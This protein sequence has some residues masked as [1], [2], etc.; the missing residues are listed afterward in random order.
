MRSSYVVFLSLCLLASAVALPVTEESFLTTPV[1]AWSSAAG[2]ATQVPNTQTASEL[3]Q[4]LLA[5]LG[6]GESADEGLLSPLG[7]APEILVLFVEPALSTQDFL[8][9]SG[10]HAGSPTSS[11]PFANVRGFLEHQNA[12]VLENVALERH[13]LSQVL[14]RVAAKQLRT[15]ITSSLTLAVDSAVLADVSLALSLPASLSP[16]MRSV[17]DV[18]LLP[19]LLA[20]HPA[21]GSNGVTDLVVVY[22]STT[23]GLHKLSE[24]FSRDDL[25]VARTVDAVKALTADYVALL[26]SEVSPVVDFFDFHRSFIPDFRG[27]AYNVTRTTYWP[28]NVVEGLMT[29]AILLIILFIGVCCICYTQTPDRFPEAPRE[30]QPNHQIL[31]PNKQ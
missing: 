25:A 13:H 14:S 15:H 23:P 6:L 2:A 27:V 20:Q 9:Y 3:E 4:S 28:P 8:I 30:G 31:Y 26:S 1:L 11:T 12:L 5:L 10:A 24:G 29:T 17:A 19:S 21:L 16:Q 7:S 18:G 22:F